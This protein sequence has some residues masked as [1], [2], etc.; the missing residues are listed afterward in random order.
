[1]IHRTIV[2]FCIVLAMVAISIV[3]VV[4]ISLSSSFYSAIIHKFEM[5]DVAL[6]IYIFIGFVVC[7][8]DFSRILVSK[9]QFVA[10]NRLNIYLYISAIAFSAIEVSTLSNA[11]IDKKILSGFGFF[12]VMAIFFVS[13]SVVH[14][15]ISFSA[16]HAWNSR[17]YGI[18]TTLVSLHIAF[19]IVALILQMYFGIGFLLLIISFILICG[20]AMFLYY[21]KTFYFSR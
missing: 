7:T 14:Y 8:E 3:Q 17:L 11:L 6:S 5:Q 4:F 18:L 12:S 19:D 10:N 9:L 1:M 2:Y 20:Y 21:I 13:K 15:L 16:I